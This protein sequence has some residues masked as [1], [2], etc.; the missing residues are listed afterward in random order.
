[1]GSRRARLP[2]LLD[3]E[4]DLPSDAAAGRAPA[5]R[6]APFALN[7]A[8]APQDYGIDLFKPHLSLGPLPL[9][10]ELR[11]HVFYLRIHATPL[12]RQYFT[13]HPPDFPHWRSLTLLLF[14]RP[15]L[16]KKV[17]LAAARAAYEAKKR[18][19]A[20]IAARFRRLFAERVRSKVKNPAPRLTQLRHNELRLFHRNS[21]MA[22]PLEHL[23]N[24]EE[25]Q[26]VILWSDN[27]PEPWH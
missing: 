13:Q 23:G 25:R 14:W 7:R 12:A 27:M 6:R 24:F 19:G 9:Y 4:F 15:H 3:P 22:D 16:E 1:M 20:D 8:A 10:R 11:G 2:G 18:A 21:E 17:D 5:R 26:S